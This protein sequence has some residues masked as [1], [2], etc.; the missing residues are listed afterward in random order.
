[1]LSNAFTN[2]ICLIYMYKE[3]SALNNLQCLISHTTKPKQTILICGFF[4]P[5]LTGT[6]H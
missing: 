1:M 6:F 5:V 4:T 3:E 2:H